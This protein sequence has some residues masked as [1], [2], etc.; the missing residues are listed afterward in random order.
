MAD[1]AD[2]SRLQFT[3]L[4]RPH[5]P[6]CDELMQALMAL[7]AEYPFDV[8]SVDVDSDAALQAQYGIYIPVLMANSKVISQYPLDIQAVC[9][10]LTSVQH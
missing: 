4:T 9:D 5:C 10:Y 6:L 1:V 2:D 7:R 3:L 8:E